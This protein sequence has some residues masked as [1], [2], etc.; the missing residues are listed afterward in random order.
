MPNWCDNV[1]YIKG[2]PSQLKKFYADFIKYPNPDEIKLNNLINP[3]LILLNNIL[4]CP[5]KLKDKVKISKWRCDN[6]GINRDIIYD[7]TGGMCPDI[8]YDD[9][10]IQIEFK[11]YTPWV[12]IVEFCK[13]IAKKYKLNVIIKYYEPLEGYAGYHKYSNTKK[14]CEKLYDQLRD[15]TEYFK[16]LIQNSFE[17]VE[18]IAMLIKDKVMKK[19]LKDTEESELFKKLY[20]VFS[21][22]LDSAEYTS[23]FVNN[24][25]KYIPENDIDIIANYNDLINEYDALKEAKTLKQVCGI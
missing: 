11:L 23:E 22:V 16:F 6:W 20:Y 13:N 14:I 10:N 24:I 19:D 18:A 9:N 21:L 4:P 17:T 5:P 7:E 1:I 3:E 8:Y 2:E 12:P 15:A 25:L